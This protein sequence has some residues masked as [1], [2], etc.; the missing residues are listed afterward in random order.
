MTSVLGPADI[1]GTIAAA[2]YAICSGP[3]D[4]Q[5]RTLG[6]G[7]ARAPRHR[8]GDE[9]RTLREA[10]NTGVDTHPKSSVPFARSCA[11]VKRHDLRPLH[12]VAQGRMFMDQGFLGCV[13]HPANSRLWGRFEDPGLMLASAVSDE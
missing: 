2:P 10:T 1:A 9:P 8:D 11:A 4:E 13:L 7:L 12:Q 5:G 3:C 6:G